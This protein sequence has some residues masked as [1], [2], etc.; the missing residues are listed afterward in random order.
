M[1][2]FAP[3]TLAIVVIGRNEGV[4]LE[5][6]L[7]ALQPWMDSVIYV[8]SGSTDDSPGM[9]HSHGARVVTL[10]TGPFTAARGRQAGFEALTAEWPRCQYVQYIDADC[11]LDA[12]WLAHAAAFLRPQYH[13]AGVCGRLCEEHAGDRFY[14][15]IAQAD[16]D[17]PPGPAEHLGG[18]ALYRVEALRAVNGWRESMIAGE[19]P[20]LCCRLRAERW[21]LHRLAQPMATHDIAMDRFGQFW[22]R[23]RRTGH[24]CAEVAWL[25]G[26]GAGRGYAVRC[27]RIVFY[28]LILPLAILTLAWPYPPAALLGTLLW[29][30]PIGRGAWQRHRA[31]LSRREAIAH[32]LLLAVANTAMT[33][34][35]LTY[36]RR[37]LFGR[38]Q[39]LI[40]YKTV[41][42][43][44]SRTGVPT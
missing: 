12:E 17:R 30:L 25:H 41:A 35:I 44:K 11:V 5:R 10:D 13:V 22:R 31:G 36:G 42:S 33:M 38:R 14:S 40:E 32:A 26:R 3:G 37:A 39:E 19:E 34:G 23:S 1:S 15:R 18:I 20:E 27:L 6:C 28:G 29:L 2:D 24:A 4:R 7:S 9:A 16:W 43:P 21:E 8:D